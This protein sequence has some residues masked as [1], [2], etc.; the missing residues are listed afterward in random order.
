MDNAE[1]N[2]VPSFEGGG[3]ES[4]LKYYLWTRRRN[5]TSVISKE[6]EIRIYIYRGW[7]EYRCCS[8][9][10]YSRVVDP[11]GVHARLLLCIRALERRAREKERRSEKIYA[12]A[13]RLTSN[14][15]LRAKTNG[16]EIRKGRTVDGRRQRERESWSTRCLHGAYT[17]EECMYTCVYVCIDKGRRKEERKD[18]RKDKKSREA[19]AKDIREEGEKYNLTNKVARGVGEEGR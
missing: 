17:C 12:H 7:R 11:D 10:I 8:E 14:A 5:R 6:K 13:T 4:I 9:H 3:E 19:R 15:N 18:G 16:D 1:E 2:F